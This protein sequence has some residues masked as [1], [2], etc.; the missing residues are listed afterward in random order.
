MVTG[1]TETSV[2]LK[3]TAS[4]DNSGKL[5][6]R[7][8]IVNLNNSAYNS[9]ASVSQTQTTFTAKFLSTNSSYTFAVY[10][11]DESGNQS[12][13][14]NSVRAQTPSDT[15]APTSP[16]LQATVLTPAKVQL[17]WTVATDNVANNCC[18]Y[19]FTM[20]GSPLTQNI[21]WAIA[22][23]GKMSAIIR[24]IAPG[25]SNSFS[26]S[27]SDYAGNVSNSNTVN[28]TTPPSSDGLPPSVPTNLQLLSS[29]GCAEVWLGWTQATDNADPQDQIEYEI[30]VNGVLSPL[31]VSSGVSYDF[32]Y[33]TAFG[34]NIF[35]LKA[36][37]RSG[38]SSGASS[39]LKL[40][41]WP[42]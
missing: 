38:N 32:V 15:T 4:T 37:D 16:A 14:S 5:S 29:N 13:D 18:A 25:S 24:H 8:R 20:N 2:S 7:V 17:T 3:W 27:A 39:P 33:G 30:Y 6:Y 1:L 31:P 23:A 42:C 35:T 22:P 40:N 36:V 11:V 28:A 10:A 34:D 19:G 9:L 26:V 41:L 21:N 12:A